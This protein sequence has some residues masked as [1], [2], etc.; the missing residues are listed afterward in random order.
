MFVSTCDCHIE[1]VSRFDIT[2][3]AASY[4]R[5]VNITNTLVSVVCVAAMYMCI[6]HS[7]VG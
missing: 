4:G 2:T 5:G 6:A 1:Y 7:V 3:V